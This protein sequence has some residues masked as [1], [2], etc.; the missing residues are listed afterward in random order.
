MSFTE[1]EKPGDTGEARPCYAGQ[2]C[3]L[4][5]FRVIIENTDSSVIITLS[6]KRLD[7]ACISKYI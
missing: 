4:G 6:M 2:T 7:I 1:D 3:E 5:V